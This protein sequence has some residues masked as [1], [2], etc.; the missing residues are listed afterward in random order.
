MNTYFEKI[1]NPFLIDIEDKDDYTY[2]DYAN[3]QN[4]LKEKDNLSSI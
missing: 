1:I 3:I 4:K 2:D